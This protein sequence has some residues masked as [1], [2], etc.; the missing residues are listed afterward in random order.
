MAVKSG[1]RE[2]ADP[3]PALREALDRLYGYYP[4]GID[5]SLDRMELLLRRL[6][7]PHRRLP[8]VIHVAGTNGKGSVVAML[9]AIFETSGKRVHAF[10]SPHLVHF[11]ERIR[12]A[13]TL[14]DDSVLL[15]ILEECERANAGQP[16]TFFELTTA[17]AF[18]AFS[19]VPADV[20]ILETGMG[21]RLDA[22][23]VVP[24]PAVTVITKI[25]YDHRDYLGGA[26]PEIAAEKAGIMK[27]GVPCVI[28]HQTPEAV[29]E[30]V[31]EVF[32]TRAASLGAPL[33]RE[34]REWTVGMPQN[35]TEGDSFPFRCSDLEIFR[36]P[37]PC[38]PG[39]H[40]IE[41]AGAAIM[42]ALRADPALNTG[43]VLPRALRAVEWPA[44][45]QHIASGPLAALLPPKWEL[46][47][48]GGHND[49][50][51]AALA[52]QARRWAARDG[53]PLHVVVGM[54]RTKAPGEFL[55]PILPHA[56]S[57][58]AIAVP[59]EKLSFT[60]EDLIAQVAPAATCPLHTA[61]NPAKALTALA[62]GAETTATASSAARTAAGVSPG[63]GGR[64]CP[65]SVPP[66]RVLI[67]GSLYLAGKVLQPAF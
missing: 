63:T 4:K 64:A 49:S 56:A 42:A 57:L 53:R 38:L 13:G 58:T 40:Q 37:A 61:Q 34:G 25:S 54:L 41:N 2:S 22:T 43:K 32:E 35:W 51:G 21:G 52:E 39:V 47:L 66:A 62:D 60:P 45:L 24:R 7:D 20:C 30:G 67:C 46:W 17:M 27:P 5:L 29:R 33:L 26:L 59:E 65:S 6:E 44:R 36:L 3:D 8:P 15:R 18:V 12:L 9:R 31:M 28:G 10:T 16:I 23:N 1:P 55:G 19:R 11:R 48:D 50:A 14:I